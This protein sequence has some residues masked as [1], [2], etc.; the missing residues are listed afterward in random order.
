MK[1]SLPLLTGLI[2]LSQSILSVSAAVPT[3][4]PSSSAAPA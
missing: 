4:P 2:I 3:S 1:S